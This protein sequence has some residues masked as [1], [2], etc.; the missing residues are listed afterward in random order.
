MALATLENFKLVLGETGSA[1]DAVNQLYLTA[2]DTAVK[3]YL[4][5]GKDKTAFSAW[6]ETGEAT[7][8]L[9]G[10]GTPL[11]VF[12]FTPI[13]TLTSIHLDLDGYYGTTTDA[14]PAST[15]QVEGTDYAMV[16]DDGTGASA[17]GL[18]LRLA[19]S[20]ATGGSAGVLGWDDSDFSSFGQMPTLTAG[21]GR[22]V[23]PRVNGCLKIKATC[24][25]ATVPTDLSMAVIEYAAFLRRSAPL[26][27]AAVNSE[28]LRDYSYS[29]DN[30]AAA[31]SVPALGSIRQKLARYR[32]IAVA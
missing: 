31:N 23:W 6:P 4:Q 10:T 22:P 30:A 32:S 24:G 21:R 3:S 18:I 5:R 15:L 2:A 11:L 12:P 13:T 26:G 1:N 8:Y 16:R 9:S 29:L 20:S 17:S 14:F 19:V 28:N 25:F 7:I 27:G